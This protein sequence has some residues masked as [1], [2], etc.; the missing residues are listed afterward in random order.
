MTVSLSSSLLSFPTEAQY[1]LYLTPSPNRPPPPCPIIPPLTYTQPDV[2]LMSQSDPLILACDGLWRATGRRPPWRQADR[3]WH[4]GTGAAGWQRRRHQ[5]NPD[6]HKP[7]RRAAGL[8]HLGDMAPH[9]LLLPHGVCWGSHDR[10]WLGKLW[11]QLL[12]L[13]PL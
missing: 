10:K 9:L 3:R 11:G 12:L 7:A 8:H 6:Q 4:R 1:P 2:F 5:D 13:R